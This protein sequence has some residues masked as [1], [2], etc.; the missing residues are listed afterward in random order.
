MKM[1][2]TSKRQHL[3]QRAENS[4]SLY[5]S[6]WFSKIRR[7]N[8]KPYIYIIHVPRHETNQTIQK[9]KT[10]GRIYLKTHKC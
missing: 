4:R 6:F 1:G 9:R 5:I 2:S 8:S 3:D 10:N 7:L